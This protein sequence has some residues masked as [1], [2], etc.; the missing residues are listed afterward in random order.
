MNLIEKAND[1]LYLSRQAIA[2]KVKTAFITAKEKESMTQHSH[3][4][5]VIVM[6]LALPHDINGSIKQNKMWIL[7]KPNVQPSGM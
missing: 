5:L 3:V 1:K 2:M 6:P 7:L 4:N